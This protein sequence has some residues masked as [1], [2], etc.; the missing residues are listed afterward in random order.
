MTN[1]FQFAKISQ[2]NVKIDYFEHCC[3]FLNIFQKAANIVT[4]ILNALNN[5]LTFAIIKPIIS[6]LR[7]TENMLF[8]KLLYCIFVSNYE[9]ASQF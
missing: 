7:Y 4:I 6:P 9:H 1:K 8:A 5:K 2:H 3:N